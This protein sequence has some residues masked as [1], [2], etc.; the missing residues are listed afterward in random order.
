MTSDPDPRRRSPAPLERRGAITLGVSL[1]VLVGLTVWRLQSGSG[2][3]VHDFGGVTMGTTYGVRVDAE[4]TAEERAR[5]RDVIRSGLDAVERSMSTYDSASELS[6]FNAHASTEPFE[7]SE[8]TLRV[9][10]MA[11]RVSRATGGAFAS[12]A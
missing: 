10:R 5:V 1:V 6:R 2:A 8:P 4:L 11:A 12:S 7:L 3:R 9:M